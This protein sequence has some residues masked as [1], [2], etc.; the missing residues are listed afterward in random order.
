MAKKV[1]FEH[2]DECP[3][4]HKV[5]RPTLLDTIPEKFHIP[6]RVMLRCDHCG[7]IYYRPVSRFKDT[8]A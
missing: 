8:N 2:V 6:R 1:K 5:D 3:S 4:C 7:G